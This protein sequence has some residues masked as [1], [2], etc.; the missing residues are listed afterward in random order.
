MY[1][2]VEKEKHICVDIGE[3]FKPWDN[4]Y[5][6]LDGILGYPNELYES[7]KVDTIPK[8]VE[9]NKYCY[10]E[11]DGFYIN[12]NYVGP[13]PTNI[14]DIPDETYHAIINDITSEVANNG[15]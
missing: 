2:I 6:S 10:T 4:G 13:D 8:G 12:P 9:V 1:I 5:P 3:T 7:Y 14:Y 15:Y 11:V